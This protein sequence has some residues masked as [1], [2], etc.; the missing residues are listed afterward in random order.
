[1]SIKHV[2]GVAA[3]VCLYVVS[4]P[5]AHRPALAVQTLAIPIA[6]PA[7]KTLQCV[8]SRGPAIAA[9]AVAFS[10]DGKTLA[11][12]GYREVLLWD[13]ANAGLAGRIGGEQLSGPVRAAAF[14]ADGRLAVGEGAPGISGSVKIFDAST[15][16]LDGSF[17][18]PPD[19]VHGVALSPDGKLLAA[20]GAYSQVHVWNVAEN[21]PA[22]T[23]V[24]H[25]GWVNDVALSIDGKLLATAGA[26]GALRVW[27][28]DDFKRVLE[29]VEKEPVRSV[30]FLADNKTLAVAVGGPSEQGIRLRRT[31]NA[32]YVKMFYTPMRV[33]IDVVWL[34]QGNRLAVACS[35][36]SVRLFDANSTRQLAA[37]SGHADWALHVAISP[38]GKTLASGSADGTVRLWNAAD[39][40][41]IATLV[42]LAPRTDR[43][44]IVTA[45][46]YFT[47][48]SA[49]AVAWHT[50]NV[51]TP[52]AEITA[53]LGKP[54]LVRKAIAGEATAAPALP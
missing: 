22:A 3:V 44:L 29:V 41:P 12:G 49:D 23:I 8:A 9:S 50:S 16:Q 1:M 28:T 4:P 36:N 47:A 7:G 33:P 48:S 13:L 25:A 20:C 42:Q 11:V 40:K 53:L 34:A 52:A 10:P 51:S 26:D 54:E 27:K 6:A 15:G 35:D 19:V 39:G 45:Q 37:M 46:G 2:I 24:G 14:A 21:K 38:D 17:D 5:A 32:R 31:D 18:D 30:A 43:W